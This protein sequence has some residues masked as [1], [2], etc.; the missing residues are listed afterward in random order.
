MQCVQLCV[1]VDL[2]TQICGVCCSHHSYSKLHV[3]PE[4]VVVSGSDVEEITLI[5][6]EVVFMEGNG[7]L[8]TQTASE[9]TEDVI[10]QVVLRETNQSLLDVG[11]RVPGPDRFYD[12]FTHE[13]VGRL[14]DP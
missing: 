8:A 10:D 4:F 11:S 14:H 9:S 13:I 7:D 2:D 12:D 6:D 1:L 5:L 3:D